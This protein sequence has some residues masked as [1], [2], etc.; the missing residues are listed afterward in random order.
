MGG[1]FLIALAILALALLSPS[2]RAD[3]AEKVTI[4]IGGF[5]NML[6]LPYD[7]AQALGYFAEEGLQVEFQYFR[8][9][10]QTA[11]AL[12][13]GDVDFTGNSFDHAIKASLQ[14]KS[15]KMIAAFTEVPGGQILVHTRLRD[16]VRELRDLRSR[17][18]GV[19]GLGSGSHMTLVYA[20]TRSG[21][22]AEEVNAIPVGFDA[23]AAALANQRVD[24]VVAVGLAAATLVH[25]G[26]AFVLLDLTA[27]GPT[28]RAYG[29]PYLNTGILTRSD[30]VAKKPDLCRKVVRAVVRAN[31]WIASH[32]PSQIVAV[33]PD[34]LVQ[35]RQLYTTALETAHSGFSRDGRIDPRA[36]QTVINA[37]QAFGAIPADKHVN[38]DD[39]YDNAFVDAVL[40]SGS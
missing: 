19:T 23:I 11:T 14:G 24:G 36:V 40:A 20:L 35:D 4:A 32:S 6:Y 37:H 5:G 10:S 27:R 25:N 22:K 30:V 15:L 21:V 31:R 34:T 1:R 16:T 8:G 33:L 26:R 12:L 39:L 2:R 7:L 9:G 18:V 29:G 3:A 13:A 17:P 28:E 38:A